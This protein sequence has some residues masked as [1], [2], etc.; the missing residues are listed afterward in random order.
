[1][2]DVLRPSFRAVTRLSALALCGLLL[3]SCI[4]RHPAGIAPATAPVSP[5]Y[6]VL[7][8]AEESDCG[9][10]VLLIPFGGKDST[11]E[12]IDRLVQEKG[13]DALV[14]VTVEERVWSFPLPIFGSHC[15]VVRGL[16]VKNAK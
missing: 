4:A 2:P 12:I 13:A 10:W 16:A 15:T 5:T 8:P 6:T 14:G 7:G 1:M 9:A 11:H 3:A